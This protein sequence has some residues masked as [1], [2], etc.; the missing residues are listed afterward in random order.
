MVHLHQVYDMSVGIR[1][2]ARNVQ[3]SVQLTTG[4]RNHGRGSV[5]LFLPVTYFSRSQLPL[6]FPI[7]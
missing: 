6:L 2:C 7:S 4:P 5:G 3:S 1:R